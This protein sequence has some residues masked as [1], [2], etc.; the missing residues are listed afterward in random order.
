MNAILW[1]LLYTEAE[2]RSLQCC[3]IP[4]GCSI[5]RFSFQEM[6]KIINYQVCSSIRLWADNLVSSCVGFNELFAT[7][8]V[9]TGW[10]DD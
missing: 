5:G 10:Q 6:H 7:L 1:P 4:T 3:Y 8:S 2:W 9:S